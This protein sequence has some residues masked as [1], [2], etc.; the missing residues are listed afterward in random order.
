MVVSIDTS[1]E[2]SGRKEVQDK[3]IGIGNAFLKG[4]IRGNS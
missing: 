1:L 2:N 4:R 3:V